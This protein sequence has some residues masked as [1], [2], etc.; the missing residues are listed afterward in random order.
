MSWEE[1]RNAFEAAG[2]GKPCERAGDHCR[3]VGSKPWRYVFIPDT[4]I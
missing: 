1:P 2:A 3:S 4:G